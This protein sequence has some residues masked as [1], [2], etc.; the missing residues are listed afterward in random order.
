MNAIFR[1][2]RSLIHWVR[3][4]H[5]RLLVSGLV[6][7]GFIA[8]VSIFAA[9]PNYDVK[10]DKPTKDSTHKTDFE[11]VHTVST[12]LTGDYAVNSVVTIDGRVVDVRITRSLSKGK[13]K[14]YTFNK[15]PLI[16]PPP[17]GQ[18]SGDYQNSFD[19]E[20][21]GEGRHVIRVVLRKDDVPGK[22]ELLDR[23]SH[24]FNTGYTIANPQTIASS[25]ESP[26]TILAPKTTISVRNDPRI[27]TITKKATYDD[28]NQQKITE[29]EIA[30]GSPASL[31]AAF[32]ATAQAHSGDHGHLKIRTQLNTAGSPGL[33][34]VTVRAV[35]QRA[36]LRP[37]CHPEDNRE[38]NKDI[39]GATIRGITNNQQGSGTGEVTF[40]KC[41]VG[42]YKVSADTP[43]GYA[44]VGPREKDVQLSKGETQL[45]RF[46]FTKGGTNPGPPPDPGNGLKGNNWQYP[47]KPFLNLIAINPN[48]AD[49]NGFGAFRNYIACKDNKTPCPEEVF[50]NNFGAIEELKAT[51]DGVVTQQPKAPRINPLFL[52]TLRSTTP[53]GNPG[54]VVERL[55]LGNLCDG[56]A[57][58]VVL[59][60]ATNNGQRDSMTVNVSPSPECTPPG[61]PP[62][63]PPPATTGNLEVATFVDTNDN[64]KL[65]Q[66]EQPLAGVPFTT[67]G[68]T[69]K[70]E[71][72]TG[73]DGKAT[74]T[75]LAP[76]GYKATGT[77]IK[78][79][80]FCPDSKET[81]SQNATVVVSQTVKLVFGLKK[82][83]APPTATPTPTATPKVQGSPTP[84]PPVVQSRPNAAVAQVKQAVG[85]LPTTGQAGLA[86]FLTFAVAASAYYGL[87]YFRNRRGRKRNDIAS[88]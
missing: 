74:F 4:S 25:Q 51:V 52:P 39:F 77:A 61:P 14:T 70:P 42:M 23:A 81:S 27:K 50:D 82:K 57:H 40:V 55:A 78:G 38:K 72:V 41:G 85:S 10:I 67:E 71:L 80:E 53:V 22:G 3:A 17:A 75:E 2:F 30:T 65:D 48:F 46:T 37:P 19:R 45:V 29:P 64:C 32:S 16:T 13:D 83:A 26:V 63:P 58:T 62:P 31:L 11:V 1:P 66:G 7:I 28:V 59:S 54:M 88:K 79:Y 84:A 33:G 76:G 15:G 87:R 68:P 73:S 21:L 18:I 12:K 24:P 6:A 86:T 34:G 49:V 8:A 56:K 36:D 44:V 35:T 5:K 43:A 20:L 60:L 47:T 69:T 9:N